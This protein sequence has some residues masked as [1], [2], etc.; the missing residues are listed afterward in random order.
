[1]LEITVD[2]LGNELV[3]LTEDYCGWISKEDIR[4]NGADDIY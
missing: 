3:M 2:D 4:K 1:M